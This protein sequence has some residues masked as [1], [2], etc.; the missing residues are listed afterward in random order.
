MKPKMLLHIG[1]R[2]PYD[3]KEMQ[4]FVLSPRKAFHVSI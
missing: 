3:K 2:L 4:D 1:P